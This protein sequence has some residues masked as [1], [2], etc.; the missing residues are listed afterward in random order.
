MHLSA[1]I[2]R[3]YKIVEN[4]IRVYSKLKSEKN[5]KKI[6][7]EIKPWITIKMEK[8]PPKVIKN[9]MDEKPR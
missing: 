8:T 7:F 6:N 2:S 4:R 3:L 9:E 1:V 5:T